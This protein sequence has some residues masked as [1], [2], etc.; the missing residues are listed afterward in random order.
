[1]AA[2][3]RW[4]PDGFD[5][6][7]HWGFL[8]P[9]W[10]PTDIKPMDIDL[11]VERNGK[12]LIHET[13]QPGK[14]IPEGQRITLTRLWSMKSFSII[15]VEGKSKDAITATATYW[16]W[17]YKPGLHVGELPLKPCDALGLIFATRQWFCWADGLPIP[18]RE[19]W[20]E[21]LRQWQIDYVKNDRWE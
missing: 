17:T 16:P 20:D 8:D 6:Q 21:E 10:K 15:H 3:L 11:I 19:Q 12:F 1:M 5:G 13:K 2:F 4:P 14:S 18:T 7:Y 9:C